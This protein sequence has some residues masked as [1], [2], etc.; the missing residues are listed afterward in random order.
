M[1]ATPGRVLK[2]SLLTLLGAIILINTISFAFSQIAGRHVHVRGQYDDEQC[3]V[4]ICESTESYRIIMTSGQWAHLLDYQRDH[5]L[6][7][8]D[9]LLVE[10]D[11]TT[12]PPKWPWAKRETIGIDGRFKLEPGTC[13]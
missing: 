10:F 1:K 2:W 9:S 5:K 8:S 3:V 4:R 12:I 13:P 7:R 6:S 11:G